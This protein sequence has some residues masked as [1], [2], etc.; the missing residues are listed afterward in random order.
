M[1]S[2][3]FAGLLAFQYREAA[4]GRRVTGRRA[5]PLL[6]PRWF[7][8]PPDAQER[9]ERRFKQAHI[10]SMVALVL[11]IQFTF[12]ESSMLLSLL[13]TLAIFAVVLWPIQAWTTAGLP[14]YDGDAS[15]L[16]PVRRF[17][18]HERQARAM[19]T[20]T[21]VGFIVISILLAIPQGIVAVQDGEWW[22]WVGLVMFSGCAVYFARQLVLVRAA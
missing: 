16:V 14:A 22:A 3:Y 11:V 17:E 12:D 6:P 10:A 13:M 9:F 1:A 2:G 19:G 7:L 4:D 21:L 5:F 18:M 15:T 8:V 20:P